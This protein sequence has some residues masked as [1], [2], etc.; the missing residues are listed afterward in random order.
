MRRIPLFVSL[1]FRAFSSWCV[2]YLNCLILNLSARGRNPPNC[3]CNGD[4]R[5][6]HTFSL[7]VHWAVRDVQEN[8]A[9][10]RDM[11]FHA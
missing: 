11:L 6:T 7:S 3:V 2:E 10:S 8:V 5:R 9:E 1:S 4:E